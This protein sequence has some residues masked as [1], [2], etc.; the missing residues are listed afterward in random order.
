MAHRDSGCPKIPTLGRSVS[1]LA[2]GGARQGPSGAFPGKGNAPTPG[3]GV[4]FLGSA[5]GFVEPPRCHPRAQ[6]SLGT[7]S[8][9]PTFSSRNCRMFHCCRRRGA[10]APPECLGSTGC[11]A[12]ARQPALEAPGN[13]F[14]APRPIHG[15]GRVKWDRELSWASQGGGIWNWAAWLPGSL[16]F[17]NPRLMEHLILFPRENPGPWRFPGRAGDGNPTEQSPAGAGFHW[18]VTSVWAA[19]DIQG[20]ACPTFLQFSQLHAGCLPSFLFFQVVL[21]GFFGKKPLYLSWKLFFPEKSGCFRCEPWWE[22]LSRSPTPSSLPR[23]FQVIFSPG[24]NPWRGSSMKET[25]QIP[26]FS[27]K[28]PLS[29]PFLPRQSPPLKVRIPRTLS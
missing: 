23:P 3:T 17:M 26:S 10:A 5:W 22:L 19:P 15:M 11:P 18:E 1:A 14:P 9:T 13:P 16:H 12:S 2:A 24:E 20:T 8:S 29:D 25:S 28:N 4:T 27:E 7:P 6:S 21:G